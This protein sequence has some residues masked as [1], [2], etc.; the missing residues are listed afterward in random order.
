MIAFMG[1]TIPPAERQAVNASSSDGC[2][3]CRVAGG[4]LPSHILYESAEVLAVLD[5]YPIREGHVQVISRKHYPYFDSLPAEVAAEMFEVG[6][7]LAPVLRKLYSV[8]QVGFMYSGRD[9]PHAH[10]HVVPLVDREVTFKSRPRAEEDALEA[11]AARIGRELHDMSI[12]DPGGN[13]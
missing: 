7:K 8:Q 3:F 5:S 4:E 11:T 13:P 2:V 10:A 1:R 12:R 6:R 9:I